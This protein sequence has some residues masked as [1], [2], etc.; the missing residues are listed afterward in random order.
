MDQVDIVAGEADLQ[1]G[2]ADEDEVNGAER[3]QA[4]LSPVK[5]KKRLNSKVIKSLPS[6]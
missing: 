1:G 6:M 4:A 3:D 5:G 2:L